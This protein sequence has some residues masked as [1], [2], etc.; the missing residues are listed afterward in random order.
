MGIPFEQ[1]S[2]PRITFAEPSRST[3]Y[4]SPPPE[5]NGGLRPSQRLDPMAGN[6]IQPRRYTTTPAPN[7]F[8]DVDPLP[9][10][11]SL[12][13]LQ[14]T[15]FSQ[16][17]SAREAEIANRIGKDSASRIAADYADLDAD[18][19]REANRQRWSKGLTR[20]RNAKTLDPFRIRVPT[21]PSPR[22][23]IETPKWFPKSTVRGNVGTDIATQL[24]FPDP[25]NDQED[26]VTRDLNNSFPQ[27]GDPTFKPDGS[28]EWNVPDPGIS[29]YYNVGLQCMSLDNYVDGQQTQTGD[30]YGYV[31]GM[32][33]GSLSAP[34]PSSTANLMRPPFTIGVGEV[35]VCRDKDGNVTGAG[36]RSFY[37]TGS[38]QGIGRSR[39]EIGGLT[40]SLPPNYTG[41]L[42]TKTGHRNFNF[43][44]RPNIPDAKPITYG[45]GDPV[46]VLPK[47]DK[48]K[49]KE[50]DEMPCEKCKF[51]PAAVKKILEQTLTRDAKLDVYDEEKDEIKLKDYKV[52]GVTATVE[53]IKL[54]YSEVAKL[55]KKRFSIGIPEW[56][57]V[58]IGA[59]R[60]QMVI[61]F[62]DKENGKIG[63][64]RWSVSIPHYNKGKE[65]INLPDYQ[66]GSYF[67]TLTLKDN[68]KLTINAKDK[69]ECDKMIDAMKPMIDPKM[70]PDPYQVQYGERKGQALS[71]K[72]VTATIAQFY[73][74]GQKDT[75]AD[76]EIECNKK[77]PAVPG[78]G[79]GNPSTGTGSDGSSGGNSAPP[80]DSSGTTSSGNSAAPPDSSGTTSSGNSGGG[81]T[82]GTVPNNP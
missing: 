29:M 63:R 26:N 3:F 21:A 42:V 75:A 78:N 31:G 22:Q 40:R 17:K 79:S 37:I 74:K 39:I 52:F 14:R 34:P 16:Y 45:D 38:N 71:T 67:A 56:W 41:T 36:P 69:A 49:P 8:A 15:D 30:Y 24:L 62:A 60:P 59:D 47:N 2:Q 11:T 12:E 73:S 4:A 53:S 18:A 64:S 7:V 19:I 50:P 77:A 61:Q 13:N 33:N 25:L 9:P 5:S 68:S 32:V 72:S 6:Q 57:A 58:R 54:L 76:Y 46:V 70:V 82:G 10:R 1:R 23:A 48:F 55:R 35:V 20:P 81:V 43:V 66:K 51:S 65:P 28:Q 27:F 80:V 44:L